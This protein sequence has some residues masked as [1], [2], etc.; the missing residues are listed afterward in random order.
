M[1]SFELNTR[2]PGVLESLYELSPPTTIINPEG[3]QP[4]LQASLVEDGTFSSE[5]YFS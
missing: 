3:E 1:I 2:Y 5:D 4:C